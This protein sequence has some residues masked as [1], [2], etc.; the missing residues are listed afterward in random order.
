MNIRF[1]RQRLPAG[2][3]GFVMRTEAQTIVVI[4]TRARPTEARDA[5]RRL[6]S[7]VRPFALVL[8]PARKSEARAEQR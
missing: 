3:V 7:T 1:V 5:I 8:R 6:R 2:I 4:A